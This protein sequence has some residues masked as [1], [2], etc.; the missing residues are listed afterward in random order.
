MR[1][2][3]FRDLPPFSGSR[4][5]FTSV[6]RLLIDRFGAVVREYDV[7]SSGLCLSV[8]VDPHHWRIDTAMRG[9]RVRGVA[10]RIDARK[11]FIAAARTQVLASCAHHDAVLALTR[12]FHLRARSEAA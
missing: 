6:V 11:R 2:V 7:D 4:Y 10:E 9:R 1:V 5:P 8:A 12:R 3:Q